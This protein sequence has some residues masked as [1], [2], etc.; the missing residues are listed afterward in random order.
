MEMKENLITLKEYA[1]LHGV[2]E[3]TIRHRIRKEQVKTAVK[4]GR[5]WFIDKNEPYSDKRVKSGEYKDWRKK[6]D[7][8]T[9][10]DAN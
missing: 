1:A 8:D 3:S 5:D 2:G 6:S 10:K 4:F 9:P 7:E